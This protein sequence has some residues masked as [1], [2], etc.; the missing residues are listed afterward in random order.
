MVLAILALGSADVLRASEWLLNGGFRF[1]LTTCSILCYWFSWLDRLV[2]LGIG[3]GIIIVL[4]L[5]LC[6]C[7]FFSLLLLLVVS[8]ILILIII[9]IAF[10]SWRRR[11]RLEARGSRISVADCA[12]VCFHLIF[13]E[14]LRI[15]AS[16][17][18][19]LGSFPLGL[20]FGLHFR[21]GFLLFRRL[22]IGIFLSLIFLLY[23][24]GG[25]L[26][27]FLLRT[28]ALLPP[29]VCCYFRPTILLIPG[30]IRGIGSER[31][32]PRT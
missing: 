14:V 11:V 30:R 4:L 9:W 25:L 8:A 13:V 28:G 18:L 21:F 12:G 32:R 19:G 23:G 31:R 24:G 6:L 20:M 27:L 15:V 2:I 22:L 26:R 17:G 10:D 29:L 16:S 7:S 1:P 3:L 5:C